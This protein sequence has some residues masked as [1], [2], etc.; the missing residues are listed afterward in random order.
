MTVTVPK[1]SYGGFYRVQVESSYGA[2]GGTADWHI[3]GNGGGSTGWRDMPVITDTTPIP[4]VETQIFSTYQ[5]GK[6]P[7]NQQAPV[8]GAYSVEHSFEMPVFLEAIDP[9]LRACL[10]SVAR[11]ETAGAAALSST[12][13]ASV[14]TLDTQPDGTEVLKFVIS[15]STAASSAA[16][17]IIQNAATQETITIGTS[18]SSVDGTYYS[19]GAYDGSVN[20]ITFSVDGTVTSGLVVVSGVDYVTNTHTLGTTNP[21]LKLEEAGLPRSASNSMF[22]TG[23]VVPTLDFNFDRTALDGLLMA[24]AAIQ[25][26]F[27][28]A[29]SAGTWAN[30]AA[31]YWHPLGSWTASLLRDSSAWDMVQ[32]ASFTIGGNTQ[33]FPVATGSQD[34]SG[35]VSGP[36]EMT[37]TITIVDEDA[38][39]WN[40]YVGQTVRDTH[41]VF[42]SP[43]NIVDSTKWTLTF[44]WTELYIES[45]TPNV[46]NGVMY[47]AE[48]AFRTTEE[49]TDGI[50]KVTNVCRMPV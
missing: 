31:G 48:L 2:G 16:I 46:I 3:G 14:A 23:V 27:P 37:G 6:R 11:A 49:A 35:K 4:A 10:G 18:A 41:L 7:M 8:P 1:P 25:G 28:A 36:S 29:A 21:S 24:T 9:W 26:Q 45:Y 42:T 12:A 17:N 43:N 50:V 30:E 20:A 33:L 13:F 15:S 44:E 40:D 32:A 47:G 34:P 38:S 39:Q 19:K 22:Y 5:A